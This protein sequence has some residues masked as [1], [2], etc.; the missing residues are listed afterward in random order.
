MVWESNI[1]HVTS[2]KDSSIEE[3][4]SP[5][6]MEDKEN[7]GNAV[8]DASITVDARSSENYLQNDDVVDV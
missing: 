3:V 5:K 8:K 6:C 2:D 1:A 4:A 7:A